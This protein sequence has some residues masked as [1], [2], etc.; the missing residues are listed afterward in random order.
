MLDIS[1]TGPDSLRELSMYELSRFGCA[2]AL[3]LDNYRIRHEDG[4][5][6]V[7]ITAIW[8]KQRVNACAP[9]YPGLAST[10]IVFLLHL[11]QE[12]HMLTCEVRTVDELMREV[13]KV[14]GRLQVIAEFPE[15]LREYDLDELNHMRDFCLA[16]SELASAGTSYF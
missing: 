2:A 7:S 5:N 15:Q 14:C 3:E 6:A 9:L 1:I 16:L 10:D 4:A 8:L 11:M 12:A 13:E